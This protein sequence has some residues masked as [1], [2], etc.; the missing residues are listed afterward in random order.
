M[1]KPVKYVKKS[2]RFSP[3]N[4]YEK[5]IRFFLAS[6]PIPLI[7]TVAQLP[8]LAYI[9]N[10][11]ATERNNFLIDYLKL[12]NITPF[13]YKLINRIIDLFISVIPIIPVLLLFTYYGVITYTSYL[14]ILP[15]ILTILFSIN[16]LFFMMA[17]KFKNQSSGM[18]I[19][20]MTMIIGC[21]ISTTT[22]LS[23]FVPSTFLNY[24][25]VF[26]FNI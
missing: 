25:T 4:C 17:S 22:R 10:Y 19:G 8:A 2:Y 18:V 3:I 21:V 20:I 5:P 23:V 1:R 16:C 11:L 14:I 26:I 6:Y 24:L 9:L 13:S 7:I 12:I 15:Y